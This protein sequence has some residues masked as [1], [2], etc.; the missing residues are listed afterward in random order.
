MAHSLCFSG[1]ILYFVVATSSN[2]DHF[3]EPSHEM[4]FQV[5]LIAAA[6]LVEGSTVT[7]NSVV[8]SS[9]TAAS[10]QAA[11]DLQNVSTY[12]PLTRQPVQGS[13]SQLF[14]EAY[15]N[16]VFGHYGLS[17]TTSF[18]NVSSTPPILSPFCS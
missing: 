7:N 9:S 2:A 17:P 12:L 13:V 5:L 6:T 15:R 14:K 16:G 3:L 8:V 1:Y 4:H 18:F 10:Y 11:S